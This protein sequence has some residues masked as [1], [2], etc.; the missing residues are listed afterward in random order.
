[1]LSLQYYGGTMKQGMWMGLV[2]TVVLALFGVCSPSEA[3]HSENY[4][5]ISDRFFTMLQQG[6][7]AEAIDYMFGTNPALKK[8]PEQADQLKTKFRDMEVLLGPYVSHTTLAESKVAGAFI[9]QHY[10]VAYERQPISIRLKYYKPHD[11]WMVYGVQFDPDLTD[12]I[13]KQ[14]DQNLSSQFK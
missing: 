14:T 8:M 3:Q 11:T 4:Q 13:Q 1:M 12:L 9:Y 5:A 6:K 10:F 2:C 7:S